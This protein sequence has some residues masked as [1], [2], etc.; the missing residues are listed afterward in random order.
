MEMALRLVRWLINV[1]HGDTTPPQSLAE[2][3]T[4]QLTEGSFV[5]WARLSLRSIEP[6]RELSEA[7]AKLF[8]RVA[9]QRE[10]QAC[11]FA[12]LLRDWTATGS[13]GAM[14]IPVE[15]VLEVVVAPL[16]AQ[17]PVLVIVMDGMSTAVWGEFV[18]G[19]KR[20]DWVVLSQAGQS[21]AQLA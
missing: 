5:D 14:V 4:Y 2:A 18:V 17:V 21:S 9:E 19:I 15:Q 11:H 13:T 10:R 8:E 1:T 20:N 7:Y 12:T 16:A 6:V 3:A